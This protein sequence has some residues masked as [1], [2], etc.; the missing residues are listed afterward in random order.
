MDKALI[1]VMQKDEGKVYRSKAE[2]MS[3]IFG[4]KWAATK[5][6]RWINLL[7]PSKHVFIQHLPICQEIMNKHSIAV[8]MHRRMWHLWVA[9]WYGLKLER[10]VLN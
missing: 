5:M 1:A 6:Y 3:K 4:N 7:H 8:S 2:E 10:D 9:L